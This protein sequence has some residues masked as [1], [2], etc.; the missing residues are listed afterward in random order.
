M[1]PSIKHS[2]GAGEVL[3]SDLVIGSRYREDTPAVR[4][5][6][7]DDLVPRIA[8]KGLIKPV[9]VRILEDGRLELIDG[10]RR[11]EAFKLL[12]F[13]YIPYNFRSSVDDA[14][15]AELEIEANEGH[16]EPPF[17]D[18]VLGIY[19]V[20]RLRKA[21][22]SAE[23]EVWTMTKT[24]TLFGGVKAGYISELVNAAELILKGDSDV[25]NCSSLT[26]VRALLSKRKL[27]EA[28][29][30]LKER[31]SSSM[32]ATISTTPKKE[33]SLL[34]DDEEDSSDSLS[35]ILDLGSTPQIIVP[36]SNYLI[37]GDCHDWLARREPE[38]VDLIYT[39]PPYGIDTADMEQ[40]VD[41]K[42]IEHSHDVDENISQ[43]EPFI[44]GAY[45]VLRDK[46]HLVF[47]Y[48]P[49]HEHLLRTLCEKH[50][51]TVQGW[52][53]LWLKPGAKNQAPYTWWTKAYECVM[54]CRKGTAT[55]STPQPL[56][57]LFASAAAEAKVYQ[58]PFFKSWEFSRWLLK[59]IITPTTVAVDTYMGESSL[60]RVMIELGCKEVYGIE[61]DPVHYNLALEHIKAQLRLMHKGNAI[62]T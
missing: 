13:Q 59:P 32:G 14:E 26:D 7:A 3:I 15:A 35:E 11:T 12:G 22:A 25:A 5:R 18:R 2:T 60:V 17:K 19:R 45:R 9:I 16:E 40:M 10:W 38:S 61:K 53:C 6:I 29:A 27:D 62:F 46:S 36:L 47:W 28:A 50:G 20:H 21:H 51:F 58:H 34:G 52:P 8:E 37:N 43:F 55:I 42:R 1:E 30:I 31:N 33:I 4:Q 44:K 23:G 39:D 41:L 24:G 54:V 48:A 57:Y 49:K 56:N